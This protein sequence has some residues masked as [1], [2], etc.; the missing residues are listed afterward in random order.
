MECSVRTQTP[1]SNWLIVSLFPSSNDKDCTILFPSF[2]FHS[3]ITIQRLTFTPFIFH[4]TFLCYLPLHTQNQ[5]S[6]TQHARP[7][8]TL[9]TTHLP[10]LAFM[11]PCIYSSIFLL[12]FHLHSTFSQCKVVR[13]PTL[14]R[15]L[16][17]LVLQTPRF[18]QRIIIWIC[19][20]FHLHVCLLFCKKTGLLLNSPK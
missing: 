6:G 16:L 1:I 7:P 2:I 18:F 8:T 11:D 17:S 4:F 15:E 9:N 5:T 12:T 3:P 19:Y 14:L 13:S 20:L 10:R